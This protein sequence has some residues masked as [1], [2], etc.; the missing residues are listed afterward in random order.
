MELVYFL[1]AEG[2]DLVKIGW[3]ADLDRRFDTL[4]TG[5]PH[6]LRLLGVHIGPREVERVYHRDLAAYRQRGEW[7]FLTHE[8]RRWLS[9]SL[10]MHYESRHAVWEFH[11]GRMTDDV[12]STDYRLWSQ[13]V[14][15]FDGKP[16]F[17]HSLIDPIENAEM[18]PAIDDLLDEER[19]A[20]QREADCE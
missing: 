10:N 17:E 12:R 4:Q 11:M 15:S 16:R 20:A 6:V 13:D 1:H 8:V 3:T 19:E 9:A 7:F 2:T 18:I 5:C 14:E